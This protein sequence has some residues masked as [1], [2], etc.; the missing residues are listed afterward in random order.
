M[1]L[2][3]AGFVSVAT[4]RP[5]HPQA[6]VGSGSDAGGSS[7][8]GQSDDAAAAAAAAH[9]SPSRLL[10]VRGN[11]LAAQ[12]SATE[13]V[14]SAGLSNGHT[15]HRIVTEHSYRQPAAEDGFG[16]H[17]GSGDDT[18]S[19]DD[20]DFEGGIKSSR[21]GV[22]LDS[23]RHGGEH[24]HKRHHHRRL[25]RRRRKMFKHSVD[26]ESGH[27]HNFPNEN[28]WICGHWRPVGEPLPLPFL[29]HSSGLVHTLTHR[30]SLRC[31]CC[32]ASGEV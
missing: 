27:A 8:T 32:L 12:R 19:S 26:E 17:G 1:S 7:S 28:C 23:H 9:K 11:T 4:N 13:A 29:L 24:H 16:A 20:S 14:F 22:T 2:D 30:A 5:Q 21:S 15:R 3:A 10:P 18:S 6:A 25:Q 31:I